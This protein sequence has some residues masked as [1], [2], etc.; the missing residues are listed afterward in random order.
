MRMIS[1]FW[2]VVVAVVFQISTPDLIK[3]LSVDTEFRAALIAAAPRVLETAEQQF[4]QY[5]GY[6]DLYKTALESLAQKYPQISDQITALNEDEIYPEGLA[7]QLS[8]LIKDN[9]DRARILA[10]LEA[11]LVAGLIKQRDEA[12]ANTM[13]NI[14]QLSLLNIRPWSKGKAFYSGEGA[15]QNWVGVLF[16]TILLTLGAPFWFNSVKTAVAWRDLL[17]PPD[18]PNKPGKDGEKS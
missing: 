10:D 4:V 1:L 8:D 3:Q 17:S 15:F 16:T 5:E 2:A 12:L 13:A 11:L 9:D 6:K 18:K 14:D 7:E